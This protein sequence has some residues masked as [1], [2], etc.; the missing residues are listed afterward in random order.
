MKKSKITELNR[1]ISGKT[2]IKGTVYIKLLCKDE[3]GENC[4][5]TVWITENNIRNIKTMFSHF[6]LEIPFEDFASLSDADKLL[7]LKTPDDEMLIEEKSYT[8]KNGTSGVERNIIGSV[9]DRKSIETNV[10]S[11]EVKQLLLKLIF[12][13]LILQILVQINQLKK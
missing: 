11:D 13:L 12:Q 8:S 4:N 9:K 3:N 6:K 5:A 10:S 2:P 7:A 1:V